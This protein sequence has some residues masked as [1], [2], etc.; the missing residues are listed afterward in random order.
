MN[1]YCARC[2][3][4]MGWRQTL[5]EHWRTAHLDVDLVFLVEHGRTREITGT[6]RR[7]ETT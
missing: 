1:I 4:P 5:P 2:N 6:P 7:E 3:A